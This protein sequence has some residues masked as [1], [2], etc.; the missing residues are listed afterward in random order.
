ML[1][2]YLKSFKYVF[3]KLIVGEGYTPP[4]TWIS[5]GLKP[6]FCSVCYSIIP[7][8]QAPGLIILFHCLSQ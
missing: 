4:L 2:K 3:A 1:L 7:L 5:Y 6:V 8:F